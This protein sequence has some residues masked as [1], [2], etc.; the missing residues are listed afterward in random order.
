[1]CAHLLAHACL[2]GPVCLHLPVHMLP[3]H[4]HTPVPTLL[5]LPACTFPYCPAVFCSLSV[6]AASYVTL[7]FLSVLHVASTML[8]LMKN[9]KAFLVGQQLVQRDRFFSNTPDRNAAHLIAAWIM[10]ECDELNLDGSPKPW[11]QEHSSY[12]H[13]QKMQ[14]SMTYAFGQIYRLGNMSWQWSEHAQGMIGNPSVSQIVS[15]Y[16]VQA[17]EVPTSSCAIIV[18]NLTDLYCFNHMEEN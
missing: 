11:G 2:S 3:V 6:H 14:A 1:M 10:N 17:G 4:A 18:N 13:A 8:R 12:S 9:C 15:T 7:V 16:M 5:H